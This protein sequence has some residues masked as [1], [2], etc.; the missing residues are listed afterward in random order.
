MIIKQLKNGKAGGGDGVVTE[1][2][3]LGGKDIRSILKK[4]FTNCLGQRSILKEWNHAIITILHKREC[5]EDL[6]IY[7]HISLLT[8]AY[9]IFMRVIAER[10]KLTTSSQP[11]EQAGFGKGF[12]TM[13]QHP[14]TSRNH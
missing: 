1:Y 9:K 10:L 8:L 14:H 13:D 4:T 7:R 11:R 12:S 5:K 2:R 3:N 6:M